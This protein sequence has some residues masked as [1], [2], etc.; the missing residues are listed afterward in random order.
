MLNVSQQ[1][2][3]NFK[4]A[5]VLLKHNWVLLA[6]CHELIITVWLIQKSSCL[7]W[8]YLLIFFECYMMK[9]VTFGKP[10]FFFFGRNILLNIYLI[11]SSH[12][13][14]SHNEYLFPSA[15]EPWVWLDQELYEDADLGFGTQSPFVHH[16][17]D[18]IPCIYS[19]GGTVRDF[20]DHSPPS[21]LVPGHTDSR[22]QSG[23]QTVPEA[24][25]EGVSPGPLGRTGCR[26]LTFINST[27]IT[28]SWSLRLPFC[29]YVALLLACYLPQWPAGY[30]SFWDGDRR[31]SSS[32]WLILSA[33]LPSCHKTISCS[34]S[35]VF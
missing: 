3:L 31:V 15:D 7:H 33:A 12:Y 14:I 20:R 16:V 21:H 9:N 11:C 23:I 28:T 18:S 19:L 10:F 26:D 25:S 4:I 5:L 6:C 13:T 32:A 30:R 8:A 2:K 24:L 1:V 34:C 35:D 27:D 29:M 22:R 17:C